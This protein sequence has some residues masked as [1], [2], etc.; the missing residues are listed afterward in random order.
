[1]LGAG[2]MGATIKENMAYAQRLVTEQLPSSVFYSNIRHVAY[3][4]IVQLVVFGYIVIVSVFKPWMK[5]VS[6]SN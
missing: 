2:Y 3:A 5:R 4:G 1:M 6:K